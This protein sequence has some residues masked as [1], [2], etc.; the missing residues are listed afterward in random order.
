[1]PI[2]E[3]LFP[4]WIDKSLFKFL[5]RRKPWLEKSE[6]ER[7]EMWKKRICKKTIIQ[8]LWMI[9]LGLIVNG[10]TKKMKNSGRLVLDANFD[11]KF[12][13]GV[14]EPQNFTKIDYEDDE[15][16]SLDLPHDY[17]IE[18]P[19]AEP[20]K[21][22]KR[23]DKKKQPFVSRGFKEL[24][25]GWYRKELQFDPS[26][27]GKRVLLDIG[28]IMYVGDVWFNGVPLGTN[29][30]GY[31]GTEH[32]LTD[33]IDWEGK[34]VV[35]VRA[36]N[37]LRS[38]WYTGGGLYR[39]VH[40]VVKDP[41][42]IARHG[43]FIKTPE[44]S[45]KQAL[46]QVQVEL[47]NFSAKSHEAQIEILLKS[48][49]GET[50]A[51]GNKSLEITK[52]RE[53]TKM[54][55]TLL[56]PNL[57]SSENPY[58]YHAEVSVHS[59]SKILDQVSESF[60]IRSIDWK[61]DQGMLVNGKKVKFHGVNVHHSFGALGAANYEAAIVKRFKVLKEMGVNG[62]R[63]AHN[64]YADSFY[65][66]ADKHGILL[67][68]ELFD[69]WEGTNK[70]YRLDFF[71]SIVPWATKEWIMRSR[72]HPSVILY[73]IGNEIWTHQIANN[74]KFK[75]WG[76]PVYNILKEQCIQYDDTRKFTVGLYPARERGMVKQD[77]NYTKS[78]PPE[79]AF[80]SDI[81]SQNYLYGGFAKDRKTYPDWL[82]FQSEAT[83]VGMGKNY[84]G[85]PEEAVGLAYWGAIMYIGESFGWPQKGWVNSVIDLSLEKRPQFYYIRSY[86]S[87]EPIVHIGIYEKEAKLV[88]WNDVKL[89]MAQMDENWNRPLNS[90]AKID[91][92]TNAEEVELFLNERSLGIQKNR[93]NSPENRNKTSWKV[94]YE[95]GV[96][97]A[98]A[99]TDGKIV[100]K[101]LIET[102]GKPVSLKLEIDN[103]NWNADGFDLQH[104][105][106]IAVDEKG[107][108]VF[109]AKHKVTF[110]V[111][112]PAKLIAVDNGD[113]MSDELHIGRQRSLHRGT[114][115]AILRADRKS[116]IVTFT[117]ESEGLKPVKINLELY[118]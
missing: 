8:F 22:E 116:G 25:I 109:D 114:A 32:D 88:L 113:M 108:P 40:L 37:T 80:V 61:P 64:P 90:T 7:C 96:L 39:K 44:I 73:S 70:N 59:K 15:W 18:Q 92:W 29:E 38:R 57:W 41:L 53:V 102:V 68:D 85:M 82:F 63:L 75:D 49:N 93:L 3:N 86:F 43:V 34:N 81:V 118:E 16:R 101:H 2:R 42:S 99:R 27:K 76:V 4:Q 112:G 11:W 50:V 71:D 60:G 111:Q 67:V 105:R 35:A 66:L 47:D 65:E 23:M 84:F 10:E 31:L 110:N 1:M 5:I 83:T 55:F 97:Q 36:D 95:P 33:H 51:R 72:N 30:Y 48:P 20:S 26:W 98:V 87:N 21:E 106:V 6:K 91:V 54:D 117:A 58:L 77:K 89:G 56:Q 45:Q 19:W 28:G 94:K 78:K 103:L 9:G 69:Q 115:L 52:K 107:R 104:I 13:L 12:Y 24:N 100:A 17:Q 74:G 46:V 79:M 62:I 14:G